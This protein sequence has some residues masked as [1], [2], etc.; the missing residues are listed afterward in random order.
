MIRG[1]MGILGCHWRSIPHV[2]SRRSEALLD[3]LMRGRADDQG[4]LPEPAQAIALHSRDC[5]AVLT[6]FRTLAA[7]ASVSV[8]VACASVKSP[9]GETLGTRSAVPQNDSQCPERW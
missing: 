4:R 8:L 1:W 2:S 5:V 7:I 9:R 6:T 3:P